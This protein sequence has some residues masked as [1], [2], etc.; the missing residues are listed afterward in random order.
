[1]IDAKIKCVAPWAGQKR[2]LAPRIAEQLGE[3]DTYIEPFVGGSSIIP[4][5]PRCREERIN[6]LNPKIVSVLRHMRDDCK[7]LADYLGGFAFDEVVFAQ[8]KANVAAVRQ[9]VA[10]DWWHAANQLIVWW[11]GPNGLA[12]TTTKG[13]FAQRHTKTGG[14]PEAR[15]RSFKKSLPALSARLEGVEISQLHFEKFLLTVPDRKGV[16]IYLDPP[17]LTKSFKYECDFDLKD[18]YHLA[19]ILNRGF[20]KTRVVVSYY[21]DVSTG[22]LCDGSLLDELYP[23]ERWSKIEIEMSKAS[24]SSSGKAKRATE[25][26]LINDVK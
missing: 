18:H 2:T 8:A 3:H 24:A 15:W 26:L 19:M 22:G 4:A 17:Y 11:M 9:I 1:M 14:S 5:R 23:P 12:G 25:V 7:D 20:R 21:D 16:A 13:W 10:P 6:D